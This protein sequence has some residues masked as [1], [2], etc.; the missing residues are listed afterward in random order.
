M[1]KFSEL[2]TDEYNSSSTKYFARDSYPF[3]HWDRL[4]FSAGQTR[5]LRET[6]HKRSR[7]YP[8]HRTKTDEIYQKVLKIAE[9]TGDTKTALMFA[10]GREELRR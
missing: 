6:W 1:F 5:V 7:R 8:L 3:F 2:P 9:E 10:E 4:G